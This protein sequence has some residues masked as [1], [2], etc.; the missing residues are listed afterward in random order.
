[1]LHE[2]VPPPAEWM[3]YGNPD[4]YH[5]TTVQTYS[6]DNPLNLLDQISFSVVMILETLKDRLLRSPLYIKSSSQTLSMHNDSVVLISQCHKQTYTDTKLWIMMDLNELQQIRKT[7]LCKYAHHFLHLPREFACHKHLGN[8]FD[9]MLHL[10]LI[11]SI[12]FAL[13][14]GMSVYLMF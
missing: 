3:K 6:A 7:I 2:N 9:H 5:Q 13:W 10:Y 12:Y 1:M 11:V 4:M 8:C 14:H